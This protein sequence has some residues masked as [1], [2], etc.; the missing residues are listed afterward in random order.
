MGGFLRQW[1]EKDGGHSTPLT[2]TFSPLG[3]GSSWRAEI[4]EHRFQP[5]MK[6]RQP[7]LH[8]GVLLPLA[9]RFVE[10]I[11]GRGGAELGDIAGAKGANGVAG[12]LK[13]GHR[14]KIERA[15][16][17]GRALRFRVE[18]PYRF[19][20]VAEKIEPHRGV[21]ARR[22]Q[23]DDTAAHRVIAGFA[24]GGGAIKAVELEPLNDA[25]HR[26][27]VTRCDRERLFGDDRAF[28]HALQNSV[29][30]G[31]KD[32]RMRAAGDA[33]EPRQCHHPL[34]HHRRMRRDPVIGQTTPSRKFKRLDI[35]GEEGDR[36]GERRH[37]RTVAADDRERN[38]RRIFLGGNGASEI[39]DDEARRAV[40]HAGE[41]HRPAGFE[42][43]GRGSGEELRR[44]RHLLLS[45][46]FCG[47]L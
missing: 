15:K 27:D 10:H 38:R 24:D 19:Q 47:R 17:V 35:G 46:R 44:R 14:H 20:G 29:D 7:M 25:R 11:V 5:A 1:F 33:G 42:P 45:P 2:P 30:R 37:A 9:D 23:I 26:G 21:H 31:E 32:G 41:G 28:R 40:G 13:F 4:I 8:A 18:A 34:R 36:A 16:L 39:G 6:Q 22:E 12:E 43:L 3:R